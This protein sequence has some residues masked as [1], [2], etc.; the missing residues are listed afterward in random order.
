[1]PT[2]E[3]EAFV[4]SF[5]PEQ[6]NAL[7]TP[8]LALVVVLAGAGIWTIGRLVRHSPGGH[9]KG[10][11]VNIED[12]QALPYL[13]HV[14][15]DPDPGASG[16]TYGIRLLECLQETDYEARWSNENKSIIARWKQYILEAGGDF[17]LNIMKQLVDI[18]FERAR[19]EK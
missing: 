9:P 14:E 6:M 17:P 1:V 4:D 11:S 13:S 10:R 3:L 16:V 18:I 12:F 8:G 2:D 7:H 19:V 15:N 5:F